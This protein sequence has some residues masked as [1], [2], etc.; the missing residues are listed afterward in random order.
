[1]TTMIEID[2]KDFNADKLALMLYDGV[3]SR[4]AGLSRA[5]ARILA[6][7]MVHCAL[8]GHVIGLCDLDRETLVKAIHDGKF[9]R[10]VHEYSWGM[11]DEIAELMLSR[12]RGVWH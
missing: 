1:M 5:D 2:S 3:F 6:E 7:A 4:S 8:T 9:T 11:A 12:A 10:G